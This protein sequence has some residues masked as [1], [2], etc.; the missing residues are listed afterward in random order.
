MVSLISPV[1]T[2]AFFSFCVSLLMESLSTQTK[3]SSLFHLPGQFVFG[4]R[5]PRLSVKVMLV[6]T[7]HHGAIFTLC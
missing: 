1:V 7:V 5:M 3:W 4:E 2:L 6:L